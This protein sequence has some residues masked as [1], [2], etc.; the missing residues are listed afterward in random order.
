MMTTREMCGALGCERQS[1]PDYIMCRRHWGM[2][3]KKLKKKIK[4]LTPAT[5]AW[6]TSVEE[7]IRRVAAIEGILP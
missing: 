7:A 2:V 3:P 5:S 4:S 6:V 1:K